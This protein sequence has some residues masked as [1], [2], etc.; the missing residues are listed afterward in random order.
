MDALRRRKDPTFKK[1]MTFEES[2]VAPS[3]LKYKDQ[4]KKV[5]EKQKIE[6]QQNKIRNERTK[7]IALKY[8]DAEALNERCKETEKTFDMKRAEDYVK[9]FEK[10]FEENLDL[11][12]ADG[13]V[14]D[15]D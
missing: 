7:E 5:S 8:F 14:L 13:K 2:I 1:D 10:L 12:P 6:L 15:Q 4:V 9:H 3:N 11:M